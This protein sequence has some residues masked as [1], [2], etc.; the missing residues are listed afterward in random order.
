MEVKL[1]NLEDNESET[2]KFEAYKNK[3]AHFM[4]MREGGAITIV[5]FMPSLTK[6]EIKTVDNSKINFRVIEKEGMLVTYARYKYSPIVIELPFS[7][8]LY[9]DNRVRDFKKERPVEITTIDSKS[10][11]TKSYRIITFPYE[12]GRKLKKSWRNNYSHY[13]QLLAHLKRYDV[14][15]LWDIGTHVGSGHNY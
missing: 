1:F 11:E 9:N 7:P 4:E 15:D 14:L 10:M 12:L 3:E 5:N 6:S 8:D 2:N 13:S